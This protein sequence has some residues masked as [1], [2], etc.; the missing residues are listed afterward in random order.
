M[1]F[2]FHEYNFH[3]TYIHD[4]YFKYL[5][6]RFNYTDNLDYDICYNDPTN[7]PNNHYGPQSNCERWDLQKLRNSEEY[8]TDYDDPMTGGNQIRSLA[9][10]FRQKFYGH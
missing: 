5:I 8:T 1:K 7:F 3:F 6:L 4:I 9:R 10:A 2:S